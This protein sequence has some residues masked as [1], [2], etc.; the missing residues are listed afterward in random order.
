M[1]VIAHEAIRHNLDFKAAAPLC[2]KFEV[3]LII[4]ITEKGRLSSIATLSDVMGKTWCDD[5]S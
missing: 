3:A 5:A 1:D 4:L 2:K